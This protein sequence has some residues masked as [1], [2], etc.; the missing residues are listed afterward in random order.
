M[1]AAAVIANHSVLRTACR[2][3]FALALWLAGCLAAAAQSSPQAPPAQGQ[4]ASGAVSVPAQQKISPVTTTVIVHG[5]LEDNYLP[6]S[7]TVGTLG[8]AP[9]KDV[10]LSAS[11]MT[12]DLLSDQVSRLLSDVVK[13]DAS[14]GDD[15]VPVGYYGDYQI[16]GFPLDPRNRT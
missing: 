7:I 3:C 9:L 2:R 14:V 1:R 12:R 15:Y 13:N 6:E 10:P 5:E 16:R 8:G 11:V 4:Q